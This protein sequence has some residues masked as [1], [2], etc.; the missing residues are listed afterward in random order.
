M[1]GVKATSRSRVHPAAFRGWGGRPA[2]TLIDL[3]VSITVIAVLISIMLPSISG[4][5]ELTRRVICASNTRQI[6][7]GLAMYADDYAGSL[8]YSEYSTKF[9][10]QSQPHNM[11][12]VRG[13]DQSSGWDGLGLLFSN[14]YLNAPQ[15]FYCPSH[16]GDHPFRKYSPQW[17]GADGRI[18]ANYQY[19]GQHIGVAST[20]R[21]AL[22]TDGLRTRDDFNHK[23]GSN[24]L[25][26]DFSMQ[27]LADPSGLIL[28]NL[29][30]SSEGDADA[31]SKVASIWWAI[32]DAEGGKVRADLI[33]PSATGRSQP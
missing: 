21:V 11:I 17:T 3:L 10:G 8:P 29:P 13:T 7:L 24:V 28:R 16:A 20:D 15:V 26:S 9:R 32:D 2:F 23:V 30:T 22:L 25:R 4:V 1:P 5:R 14:D 18:F 6:G 31:A 12:I 27:W 33:G 19:R